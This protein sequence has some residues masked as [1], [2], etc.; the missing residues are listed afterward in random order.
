MDVTSALSECSRRQQGLATAADLR[1][2]GVTRSTL[3]RALARGEVQ[4]VHRGVYSSG[5]LAEWP[6]FVVGPKGVAPA[7]VQRV[8]AALLAL[9]DGATAG[10]PTAACLRGWGLLHEPQRVVDV[11][12]PM[13]RRNR[14]RPAGVRSWQ[15]RRPAREA[16]LVRR[17]EAPLWVTDAVTTVLDCIRQMKPEDAVV[18]VDSA[19][20]SRQLTLA[21]LQAA[22]RQLRGMRHARRVRRALQLC[23]P[24]SGSV[25][26][27][28]LRLELVKAGL[29][30]LATQQVIRDRS[31]RYVLRVDFC[32]GAQR[33]VV[34]ADGARWHPEPQ[35]DRTLD[36]RLVAAGW[37]VLRFTWR[38]V[39]HDPA[40][41]VALVR[42]ALDAGS[43]DVQ[44]AA[45]EL[46]S[47]A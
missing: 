29:T 40:E 36:N 33:L 1:A 44:V 31:G 42:A 34:E 28:A 32:F 37:R 21:E 15:R 7:F 24:E 4:R 45:P 30:G 22:V 16:L 9:G 8:R 10:G 6:Q 35:R 14:A 5:A 38:E 20:R 46:R 39:M 19:L 11:V 47:A 25:L 41:V 3:S 18:L 26:E 12:V 27:S 2:V 43:N 17:D 13:G 23:D